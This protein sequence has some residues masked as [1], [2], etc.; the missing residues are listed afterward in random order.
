MRKS[1]FAIGGACFIALIGKAALASGGAD[2]AGDTANS[3]FHQFVI[4]GGKIVWFVLLPMSVA[5]LYLALDLALTVRRRRLLPATVTGEILAM[6]HAVVP[7]QLPARLSGRED[8]V[9]RTLLRTLSKSRRVQADIQHLQHIA[10]EC[11]QEQGLHL[12]RKVEWCNI[13]GNVA[14]MVGLF[15]TVFGMIQAFNVL[16]IAGGQPPHDQLAAKISI[17]LVTTFWGLLIAIPALAVHG[18]FRTRVETL[19]SEAAVEVED[20][21]FEIPFGQV[22]TGPCVQASFAAD[23]LEDRRTGRREP[24]HRQRSGVAGESA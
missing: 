15:G 7:A 19:I 14:P 18:I 16:G 4:A 10:A 12:L 17:A 2:G 22:S 6:A 21:L 1:G 24:P 3:F 23:S 13:I 8:L 9:S 11:L 20:L 5:A